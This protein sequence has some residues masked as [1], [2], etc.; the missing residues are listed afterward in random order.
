MTKEKEL[1]RLI[2][3]QK[4][5]DTDRQKSERH[6]VMSLDTRRDPGSPLT[7]R[8][9]RDRTD[10]TGCLF[11]GSGSIKAIVTTGEFYC[12]L[13]AKETEGRRKR[14]PRTA[15]RQR[16]NQKN[17]RERYAN[18]EAY[19]EKVKADERA[20]YWSRKGQV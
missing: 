18:D 14:K 2:A 7:R 10:R 6:V 8:A 5:D 1:K 11:H 13:C 9:V 3:E 16:Q 4:A 15:T 19:R 20:R 12:T 17:K